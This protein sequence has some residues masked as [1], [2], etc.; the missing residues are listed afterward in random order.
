M[1]HGEGGAEGSGSTDAGG[2]AAM[3]VDRQLLHVGLVFQDTGHD[4]CGGSPDVS[5]LYL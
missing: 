4:E 5:V 3:M 2:L 1:S